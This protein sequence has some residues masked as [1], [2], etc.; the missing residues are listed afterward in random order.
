MS[1]PCRLCNAREFFQD[2]H[3]KEGRY[4]YEPEIKEEPKSVWERL[5]KVSDEL[6]AYGVPAHF[7]NELNDICDT[8]DSIDSEII[9][10]QKKLDSIELGELSKKLY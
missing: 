9:K 10:L 8:L 1:C 5:G 6:K 7:I 2:I 4:A 3:Y